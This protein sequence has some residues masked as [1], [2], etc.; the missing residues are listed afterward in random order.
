MVNLLTIN[1][2][3]SLHSPPPL[4]PLLW[5][6]LPTF[7]ASN[8]LIHHLP[9]HLFSLPLHPFF[10]TEPCDLLKMQ[11]W[12]C[13]PLCFQ[14]FNDFLLFFLLIKPTLSLQDHV[15]YSPCLLLWPLHRPCSSLWALATLIIFR[16]E[17]YWIP[18]WLLL[19]LPR[20]LFLP[21]TST[22]LTFKCLLWKDFPNHQ[23]PA[24]VRFPYTFI[25]WYFKLFL[26]L[27]GWCP[28][29]L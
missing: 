8:S 3:N 16:S 27:L 19:P 15:R 12:L 10:I 5:S 17:Q 6:T 2:E 21:V 28:S 20:L 9:K 26:I 18:S 1:I 13:H 29:P 25:L 4:P 14:T 11:T 7:L 23:A 24:W 22:P